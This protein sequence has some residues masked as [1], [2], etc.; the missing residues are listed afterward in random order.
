MYHI[1]YLSLP[2]SHYD[3][4]DCT[5]IIHDLKRDAVSGEGG[6]VYNDEHHEVYS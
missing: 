5:I 6:I 4:Q 2:L 3:F 1:C